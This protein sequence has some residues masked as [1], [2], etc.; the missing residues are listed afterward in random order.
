MITRIVERKDGAAVV[1]RDP[2]ARLPLKLRHKIAREHGH[3]FWT[4]RINPSNGVPMYAAWTAARLVWSHL[5][6]ESLDGLT[7]VSTCGYSD[8]VRPDC[9]ERVTPTE[10]MRRAGRLGGKADH[11]R[12]GE[13][14]GRHKLTA[15]QVRFIY[16]NA[17]IRGSGALLAR[18]FGVR[19]WAISKIKNGVAWRRVTRHLSGQVERISLRALRELVESRE[20]EA[21]EDHGAV[22]RH[23][24]EARVGT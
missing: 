15:D 5:R 19:A 24:A 22:L 9:R 1:L 2:L 11:D 23:A 3:W 20:A 6:T 21:S 12:H 10:C 8:C 13:W 4:G 17:R 7:L 14:N 18:M 16:A